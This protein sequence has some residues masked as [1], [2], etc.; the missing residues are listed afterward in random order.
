[1]SL[2]EHSL[3]SGTKVKAK[4]LK[5]MVDIPSIVEPTSSSPSPSPS[6]SP[7]NSPADSKL[8]NWE[9]AYISIGAV[10]FTV[11]VVGIVVYQRKRRF[12][13]QAIP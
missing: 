2:E 4:L 11:L 1:M 9:I 5:F 12:Q 6:P 8:S 3:R 7:L 13:Y 10:C